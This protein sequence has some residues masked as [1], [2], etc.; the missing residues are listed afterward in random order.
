MLPVSA[1]RQCLLG[2]S[3]GWLMACAPAVS[4][5]SGSAPSNPHASALAP[6]DGAAS[7]E[8]AGVERQV[9]GLPRFISFNIP[10][11]HYVEDAFAFDARERYRLPLE[12]EI[13]DA[14]EAVA[15]AGGKVVRIYALSV[16]KPS[17]GAFTLR[18]VLGPGEFNEAAFQTLDLVLAL[19]REY[20]IS[21]ILPFVDNWRWWGGVE[22]YAAFRGKRRADFW[23]DPQLIADFEQ[24]LRHVVLRKNTLTGVS[25]RDDPTILAWETGNELQAPW[26]W[27]E[28]IARTL[29]QL[30]PN[31]PVIDGYHSTRVRPE[32][33]ESEWI[34]IL[35]T[36]HYTSGDDMVADI[37]AN[38]ELI[39]ARKPY[40]IGE[41]GFIPAAQMEAVLDTVIQGGAL[42][43]LIWSLRFRNRDGGFYWH[44]E[45]DGYQSY[46]WPGFTSGEAYE[47]RSVLELLWRKAAQIEGREPRALPVPRAPQ[48]VAG[49]EPNALSWR[50][51]AGARSYVLQR[52]SHAEGPWKTLTEEAS[53]AAIGYR[54]L[55]IDETVPIG[56]P[57]FYRVAAQNESG[58]SPFSASLGPVSVSYR[59]F[60]DELVTLERASQ[61]IGQV[62]QQ[63]G[64][65]LAARME[66]GRVAGN[67]A[68]LYEVSGVARRVVVDTLLRGNA[69]AVRVSHQLPDGRFVATPVTSEDWSGGVDQSAIFRPVRLSAELPEGVRVLRLDLGPKSQL[70]RVV[71]D[72][73]PE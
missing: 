60:V 23:T 49:S 38:L 61:V 20:G 16:R 24:T 56:K 64:D 43:A 51:S 30:D 54:P 42:G 8:V 57:Y 35:T 37:R 63:H 34:D 65:P 50:G 17:D 72:Y 14:L 58:R 6:S 48:W 4:G 70:A 10:N 39:D 33:L 25:Y 1:A 55:W 28:R 15:Q 26:Q 52:A 59:R 9:A 7:E 3:L 12:Y 29:K 53:D 69:P 66:R 44:A 73:T 32:A 62:Q 19:A 46:H 11:L 40:F 45:A 2:G 67:G 22:E 13:R 21:L 27:T 71:V 5:P 41:F 68:L 18:H 36:H 31:H 47:E